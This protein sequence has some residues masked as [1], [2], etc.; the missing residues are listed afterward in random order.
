MTDLRQTFDDAPIEVFP[1]NFRMLVGGASATLQNPNKDWLSFQCNNY[2]P[3]G[4]VTGTWNLTS[5]FAYLP[6][7][8]C[9]LI[10]MAMS[11]PSKLGG[12]VPLRLSRR[13]SF[14]TDKSAA[15]CWDGVNVDSANH[16]DHVSYA[17]G[18]GWRCPP[19]HPKQ[20]P[21]IVLEY[22]FYAEGYNWEDISLSSGSM[23]GAGKYSPVSPNS[24]PAFLQDVASTDSYLVGGHGDF[25]FGWTKAGV[26]AMK[27]AMEHPNC[28][29]ATGILPWYPLEVRCDIMVPL[30]DEAAMES[31][32]ADINSFIAQEEVGI[33]RPVPSLPG[34]N[35]LF[36]GPG[37]P[38]SKPPCPT[39]A[40]TPKI[41][42][43][44]RL[45][46]WWDH[47]PRHQIHSLAV[48]DGFN[49]VTTS[50]SSTLNTST[51][52]STST[53][54][55]SSISS[56][57]TSTSRASSS[58]STKSS[59]ATPQPTAPKGPPSGTLYLTT[60][61][62]WDGTTE[63]WRWNNGECKTLTSKLSVVLIHNQN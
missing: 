55:T 38:P 4:D 31:C 60:G 58:T 39:I 34:C 6:N 19:S 7:M 33:Q 43:P 44:S 27:L 49:G 13:L 9:T 26:A 2:I 54:K 35:P 51:T 53:R 25:Y 45:L 40:P 30:A 56:T 1:E 3:K 22:E 16:R 23:S 42:L 63:N 48:Y 11:F 21:Q 37:A 17:I 41:G 28:T 50:A 12:L 36:D 15:D 29:H 20:I 18:E 52:M 5:W 32:D 47:D 61:Q 46:G 59:S 24:L 62:N 8:D 10:K 14:R 57:S